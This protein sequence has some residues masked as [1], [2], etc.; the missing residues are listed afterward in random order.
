MHGLHAGKNTFII[1]ISEAK[2]K[3]CQQNLLDLFMRSIFMFNELQISTKN[4]LIY[5][6]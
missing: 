3:S 2:K 6:N 1:Y 5:F 4:T